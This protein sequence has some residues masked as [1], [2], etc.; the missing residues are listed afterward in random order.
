M[1]IIIYQ[2]NPTPFEELF[3]LL[4]EF[5]KVFFSNTK[6][7]D[8]SEVEILLPNEED[9]SIFVVPKAWQDEFEQLLQDKLG[10]ITWQKQQLPPKPPKEEIGSVWSKELAEFYENEIQVMAILQSVITNNENHIKAPLASQ[11]SSLPKESESQEIVLAMRVFSA[12]KKLPFALAIL[13]SASIAFFLYILGDIETLK[14]KQIPLMLE[15]A[16]VGDDQNKPYWCKRARSISLEQTKLLDTEEICKEKI[17]PPE[18]MSFPK[19]EKPQLENNDNNLEKTSTT[20]T[21]IPIVDKEQNHQPATS[22]LQDRLEQTKSKL[23]T[24]KQSRYTLRLIEIETQHK[25]EIGKRL[26]ELIK[27]LDKGKFDLSQLYVVEKENNHKTTI[28]VFYKAFE[29]YNDCKLEKEQ[30][31]KFSSVIR[32]NK[33]FCSN[34]TF[35]PKQLN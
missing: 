4:G 18:K 14:Q 35:L 8:Q 3:K 7:F 29:Q 26:N 19:Q 1:K 23:E 17:T 15:K 25:R 21:A 6:P 32:N 27:E 2:A 20:E 33:P 24:L 31:N 28:I 30:L 5:N 13:A 22:I 12:I 16:K 9:E 34:F 11:S 10:D